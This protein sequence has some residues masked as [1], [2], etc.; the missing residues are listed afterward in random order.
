MLARCHIVKVVALPEV[1]RLAAYMALESVP[2]FGPQ[3][4]R[5]VIDGNLTPQ[6]VLE[7]PDLLPI[8]GKR[9]DGFREA[10]R[11][12]TPGDLGEHRRLASLALRRADENDAQILLAGDPQYPVNLWASSHPL[13]II[14]VQGDV[15]VLKR[16]TA[17]ACVGSREMREPYE[18]RQRE[19]AAHAG[20]SGHVVVSGFALGADTVAHKAAVDAG[21]VTVCVMPC[22]LD[23]PFPPEN[24]NFQR[25]LKGSAGAV[26]VSEFPFATGAS[27]LTLRK[28]NKTIVALAL[29]VLIGQSSSKGGAMN[30]F[31]FGVEQKKPV[32]T[33]TSDGTPATTGN[34][35]IAEAEIGTAFVSDRPDTAAWERWL[36][37]L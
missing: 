36:A 37:L 27:T 12:L 15:E 32:A 7:S 26:F 18:S 5:E 33:F 4:F 6:Q 31:R 20:T 22:G 21:G 14:Y 2:Q 17:V 34:A 8:R 3:K 24:R 16:R 13:P 35:E 19:F 28:R 29:G 30:A 9:G 25:K 23:R 1:D 10:L 11:K